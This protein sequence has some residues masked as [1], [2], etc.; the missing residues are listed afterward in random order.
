[1]KGYSPGAGGWNVEWLNFKQL[2]DQG[3]SQPARAG[4]GFISQPRLAFGRK[5]CRGI[6]LIGA[7]DL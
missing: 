3:E 1:M 5:A 6:F 4:C 2:R 7:D